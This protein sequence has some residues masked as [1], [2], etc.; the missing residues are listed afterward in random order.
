MVVCLHC[1]SSLILK[2]FV[3][4]ATKRRDFFDTFDT[5]VGRAHINYLLH[6]FYCFSEELL[7]KFAWQ[8]R[9][10]KHRQRLTINGWRSANDLFLSLQSSDTVIYS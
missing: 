6:D 7:H 1:L 10:K 9:T 5:P 8:S 2:N 4:N 3:I